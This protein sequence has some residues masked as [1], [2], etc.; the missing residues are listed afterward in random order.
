MTAAP[1]GIDVF[2]AAKSG[3]L[4]FLDAFRANRGDLNSADANG[5]TPLLLAVDC[6]Q[7][8][9]VRFLIKCRVDL[10]LVDKWGQTALML[11]A[12]RNDATSTRLLV[13]ARADLKPKA[14]NGLTAPGYAVDNHNTEAAAILKRAGAR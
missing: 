1:H 12:G 7:H 11:A 3:N 5:M 6:R 2:K 10:N 14:R 4:Q 9:V 13:D 8:D